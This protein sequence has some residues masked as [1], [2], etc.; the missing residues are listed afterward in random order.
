MSSSD[1]IC[2]EGILEVQILENLNLT[3]THSGLKDLSFVILLCWWR[4]ARPP[5]SS[6][7]RI[8]LAR[9]SNCHQGLLSEQCSLWEQC[10]QPIYLNKRASFLSQ[11][12]KCWLR[13]PARTHWLT[14]NGNPLIT[15][16]TC[17]RE[18]QIVSKMLREE[19]QIFSRS[20]DYIGCVQNLQMNISLKDDLPVSQTYQSIP[21]PFYQEMKDYLKDLIAQGWV[22][23]SSSYSSPV[24][25]VKKKGWHIAF[26]HWQQGT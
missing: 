6:V 18:K 9:T 20:D 21:K 3:R 16:L 19:S 2:Q 14:S 12:T 23:K 11:S 4:Q 26:M 8:L 17:K 25:F 10:T 22:E 1:S 5:K 15:W 24:V 13:V 7:Y